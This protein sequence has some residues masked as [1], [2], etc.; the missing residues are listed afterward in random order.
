MFYSVYRNLHNGKWSIRGTDGLV[1][2]HA[3]T[4]S[5]IDT[6]PK[7]SEA[8]RQRV[9]KEGKKNVHAFMQGYIYKAEGFVPFKGRQLV[10]VYCSAP[11]LGDTVGSLFQITYDPYKWSCFVKTGSGVALRDKIKFVWLTTRGVFGS[12]MGK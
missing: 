8:G 6:T 3:D 9:I 1:V 4:V 7:M 11:S 12:N 10:T 5:M 2:G